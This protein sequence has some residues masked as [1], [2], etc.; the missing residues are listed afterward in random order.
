ME[1]GLIRFYNAKKEISIGNTDLIYKLKCNAEDASAIG[2]TQ[3][4][5][6]LGKP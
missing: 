2:Q 4:N 6:H 5:G 3:I 1:S